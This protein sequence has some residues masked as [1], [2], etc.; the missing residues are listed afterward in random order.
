[1]AVLKEKDGKIMFEGI[2]VEGKKVE[3]KSKEE[4]M[5]EWKGIEKNWRW[6]G[7]GMFD[8]LMAVLKKD[9]KRKKWRKRKERNE[10]IGFIEN[11]LRK[12]HWR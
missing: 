8:D 2:R 4:K 7:R 1:M 11:W 5:N 6:I 10:E 9:G 3:G 12:K